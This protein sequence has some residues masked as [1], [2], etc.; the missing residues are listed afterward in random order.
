MMSFNKIIIIG[1]CNY[2]LPPW[3]YNQN[4]THL[5]TKDKD[6]QEQRNTIEKLTTTN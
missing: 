1:Q 4:F 3:L 6:V 2:K 5:S